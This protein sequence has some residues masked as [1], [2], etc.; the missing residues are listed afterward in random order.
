M[1]GAVFPDGTALGI[2]N[3]NQFVNYIDVACG[4]LC[5]YLDQKGTVWGNYPDTLKPVPGMTNVVKIASGFDIRGAL[6]QDGR[7]VIDGAG[8]PPNDFTNIIDIACGLHH[9]VAAKE[10]GTVR[11]WTSYNTP[12]ILA[13]PEGLSNVV[14]VAAEGSW[15]IALKANG[16]AVAWGEDRARETMVPSWLTNAYFVAAGYAVGTALVPEPPPYKSLSST[17]RI[18][19]DST[20]HNVILMWPKEKEGY[21]LEVTHDLSGGNWTEVKTEPILNAEFYQVVL[22]IQSKCA[23]YRL[24]KK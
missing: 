15:S 7:A 17:L 13:V 19:L 20:H 18:A 21:I 4:G 1:I 2:E 14:Q 6:T 23:F 9:I 24:R 16:E 22:P 12:S 11:V 3:T 8:N 5:L 10:D